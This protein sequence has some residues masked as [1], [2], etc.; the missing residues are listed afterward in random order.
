MT[1]E[2]TDELVA[3][4][5]RLKKQGESVRSIVRRL[6]VARTPLQRAMKRAESHATSA[7]S[8]SPPTEEPPLETTE[9]VRLH[10]RAEL[11]AGISRTS[12][13]IAAID[14]EIE[15]TFLGKEIKT[16]KVRDLMWSRGVAQDKLVL[17]LAE[18]ERI[19]PPTESGPEF[20]ADTTLPPP[21]ATPPPPGAPD[22]QPGEGPNA[23]PD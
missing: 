16:S 9:A 11:A 22:R 8:L 5:I 1:A 10:V 21:T 2:L 15:A 18:I 13:I 6:G 3:E 17:A 7:P 20:M 19:D 23:S 14:K 4:A 12:R